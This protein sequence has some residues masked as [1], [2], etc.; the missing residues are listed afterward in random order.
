MLLLGAVGLVLLI[1]AANLAGL[2]LARGA[3]R[4]REYALRAALGASSRR[5]LR[6]VFIEILLL[7]TAAGSLGIGV[8]LPGRRPYSGAG[9]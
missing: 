6:L 9:T 1:A 8:R 7:A 5:I 2:Q 4:S 3:G